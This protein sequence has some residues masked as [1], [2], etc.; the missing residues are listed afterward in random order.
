MTQIAECT[1]YSRVTPSWIFGGDAQHELSDVAR[2]P[3][4]AAASFGAAI[5]FACH[6]AAIP[7]QQGVRRDKR[8]DFRERLASEL[9]R[10]ARE[11]APLRV[12]E[13]DALVT[14]VLSEHSVFGKQI[15][16]DTLV[17]TRHPTR[18]GEQEE[19]DRQLRHSVEW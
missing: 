15:L 17:V 2:T 19:L 18:D 16:G 6:Q 5:V 11:P 9:L 8:V 7:S 1:T 12:G 3:R 4:L 14:K 13:A 10:G